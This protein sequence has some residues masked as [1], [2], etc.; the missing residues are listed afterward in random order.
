MKNERETGGAKCTIP[1]IL[2]LCCVG[3]VFILARFNSEL[4]HSQKPSTIMHNT[5]ETK[6]Y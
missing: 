2:I 3:I 5:E 4:R 6:R 1:G